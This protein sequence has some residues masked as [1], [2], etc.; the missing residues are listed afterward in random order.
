M[1]SFNIFGNP[2]NRVTDIQEIRKTLDQ[3]MK[4]VPPKIIPAVFI[5]SQNTIYMKGLVSWE[6]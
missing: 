3:N 2:F 5:K 4:I 1:N 6:L